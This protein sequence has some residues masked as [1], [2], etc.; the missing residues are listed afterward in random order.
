M[1]SNVYP[2]R[3]D[4]WNTPGAIV[5]RD[6]GRTYN[7]GPTYYSWCSSALHG[8]YVYTS[9]PGAKRCLYDS[10]KVILK[11]LVN[12]KDLLHTSIDGDVATYERVTVAENQPWIDWL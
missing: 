3:G 1:E 4:K 6:K 8:I 12:P 10:Q 5:E 7:T 9:E 2:R 11:V